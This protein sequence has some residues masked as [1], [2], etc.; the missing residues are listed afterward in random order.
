MISK[1][2]CSR[3]YKNL[4]NFIILS[5][6]LFSITSCNKNNPQYNNPIAYITNQNGNLQILS[7]KDFK[8]INEVF[9]GDGARGIGITPDGKTLAIAVRESN[10]LALVDTKT[11]EVRK[12]IFIGQNPE[13]VRVKDDKAFVSFEPA[14]IG[15][16]PPKPG[17]KEAEELKQK[18][19]EDDEQPARIAIVDL[20]LEEKISEIQGGMETEGI[21]FSRDGSKLI[22]TNEADENLSVHEI[23]TGNLITKIDTSNYG[24]RPRG[25]KRS[26][27]D[28]FY[29]ATIEYGDR[30]LK[31]SEDFKIIQ[32]AKTGAVPYGISFTKNGE[33]IFVALSKGKVI[34]VF[35]AKS[36]KP[37][38]EISTGNR[39]WHFS[40]TPD[41]KHIVVACGRSNE[42]L[43]IETESGKLINKFSNQ[44]MPWGVVTYPKSMGSLDLPKI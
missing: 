30:I 4:S 44:N 11:F 13:F 39:C 2:F 27:T 25:I 38:R 10:D 37:V 35:D 28:N 20:N 15:G 12:R 9:V 19:E 6:F 33:Y 36:L 42:I 24:N 22:V 18:R 7:L 16:P 23:S 41:E 5:F 34:Q 1:K 14:A 31:I 29:V 3:K 32:N 40:F 17:S 21:E 8:I 26:P 43:L